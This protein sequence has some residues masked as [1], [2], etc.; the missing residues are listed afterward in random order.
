MTTQEV[1]VTAATAPKEAILDAFRAAWRAPR[2]DI[3]IVPAD[4]ADGLNKAFARRF[5]LHAVFDALN[6]R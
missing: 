1:T 5:P 6:R 3:H 2:P 4:I